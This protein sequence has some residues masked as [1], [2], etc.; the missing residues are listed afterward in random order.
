MTDF[1]F[2]TYLSGPTNGSERV[3]LF[4]RSNAGPNGEPGTLLYRSGEIALDLGWWRIEI[5]ELEVAVPGS[6]TW[7]VVMNGIGAEAQAGLLVADPPEIGASLDD[8]WIKRSDGIWETVLIDAGTTPGNLAASVH[9]RSG[10]L[11]NGNELAFVAR[12]IRGDTD[13]DGDGLE[14]SYE[15]YYFNSLSNNLDSDPDAD[16]FAIRTEISRGYHPNAPDQ[17]TEGGISRRRSETSLVLTD[18]NLLRVTA[19]SEPVGFYSDFKILTKGSVFS[20]P[21]QPSGSGFIGWFVGSSRVDDPQGFSTGTLNFTVSTDTVFVARFIGDVDGD[22]DGLGDSFEFFYF[23]GLPNNLDS[24]PDGDGFNIRTEISRNYHANTPDQIMEGGVSRRR[25]E[26]ILFVPPPPEIVGQPVGAVVSEGT[27]IVL[28]VQA[29]GIG[30]LSYQW[31]LNG[32]NLTGETTASL[33]ISSLSVTNSGSYSVAVATPFGAVNSDPALVMVNAPPLPFADNF[34][35]AVIVTEMCSLARGSNLV[36]SRETGEPQHHDKPGTNSVWLAWQPNADGVA[37]FSTRG[38]SFDTLLAVY[39]GSGLGNLTKVVS[40]DDAGGLYTSKVTFSAM[41]G[42]TYWIAVD[43]L[44]G[45]TGQILLKWCLETSTLLGLTPPPKTVVGPERNRIAKRSSPP[46]APDFPRFVTQ[47]TSRTVAIGT[48]AEFHVEAVARLP[49]AYQWHL[50]RQPIVGANR[51]TLRLENVQPGNVGNYSVAVWVG[52][53]TNWSEIA[54]LQIGPRADAI[55]KDKLRDHY[56]LRNSGSFEPIA[57]SASPGNPGAQSFSSFDS[58]IEAGEIN[59]GGKIWFSSQWLIVQAVE[60]GR[61]IVEARAN[62]SGI[63][64]GAYALSSGLWHTDRN[65]F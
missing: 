3:E 49:V 28:T 55:I 33:S 32:V 7:S 38:S 64:L 21:A 6:F 8:L 14:N 30:L 27:P 46:P 11:V 25:A 19:L 20:V 59:V 39:T 60:S 62:L 2:E 1:S 36:S 15:L 16:G 47:P 26:T 29:R 45:A 24:D 54:T 34:A 17:L 43:G 42:Q 61:L 22:G 50:N 18:A 23:N 63:G 5:G 37:T 41:S 56:R 35:S 9:A 44:R 52:S 10:V 51:D 58:K 13:S 57:V 40:D 12:F 65:R 53:R 4:L 48:P 31:R